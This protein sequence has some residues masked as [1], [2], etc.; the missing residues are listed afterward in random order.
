MTR[1][2][3]LVPI[4]LLVALVVG[5]AWRIV[6]PP[7]SAIPS[8][9]ISR[10]LPEFALPAAL[11]AKPGLRSADMATGEPR[12]L[13][14][15]ASWCVPCASEAEVLSEL[16]RRGVKIDA[17]AIRDTPMAISAFLARHGDP[18]DRI[19]ADERSSVQIS[20]GSSGVPET[21]VIDGHGVMRH[22][23]LGPLTK[24]N[25]PGV[26]QQLDEAR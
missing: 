6:R 7:D 15:F 26:L 20:L 4:L 8:Q 5:F 16:R 2:S 17:I 10:P 3:R 9:M 25:I 1:G 12:L 18:Y 23:Y 24:A 19:G 22:Q 21:F 14:V 11:P 13:N